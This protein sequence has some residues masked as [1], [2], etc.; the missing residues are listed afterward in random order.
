LKG[1]AAHR[2]ADAP[3]GRVDKFGP[4]P[5][6]ARHLRVARDGL[7]GEWYRLRDI[8]GRRPAV[9]AFGGATGGLVAMPRFAR[10]FASEGY[11]ALALA[12]FKEP[13]LPKTLDRIPLEYFARARSAGSASS[14]VWIPGASRFSGSRAAARA[15]CSS[16][17][18]IR[19]WF[20]A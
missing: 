20:T 3:R 4:H 6:R 15:R 10:G 7:Y 13:G 8:H 5:V 14:P 12:Y 11:P 16:G 9:V 19:G 17:R 2:L 1:V 18:H